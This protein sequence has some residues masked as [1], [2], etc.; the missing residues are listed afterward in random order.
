MLVNPTFARRSVH[1]ILAHPV[2]LCS[3][4]VFH[5]EANSSIPMS[6]ALGSLVYRRLDILILF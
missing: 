4:P 6:H 1:A 5:P 3:E 2:A